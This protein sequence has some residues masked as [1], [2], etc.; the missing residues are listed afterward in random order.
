MP[1]GGRALYCGQAEG[2]LKI[3]RHSEDHLRLS[4]GYW[5][6]PKE[7][8]HSHN[9]VGGKQIKQ[10]QVSNWKQSFENSVYKLLKFKII[11][12]G[13]NQM[14]PHSEGMAPSP[15]DLLLWVSDLKSYLQVDCDLRQS[16]WCPLVVGSRSI[17]WFPQSGSK[18]R[19]CC[20]SV[21]LLFSVQSRTPS[22]GWC[23][24]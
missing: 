19:W 12:S 8:Q 2:S 1:I 3:D 21:Q 17:T 18:G 10:H 6:C 15:S 16:S 4:W 13:I 5:L 9:M 14:I 22:H 24:P 7:L 23:C 11:T 20:C